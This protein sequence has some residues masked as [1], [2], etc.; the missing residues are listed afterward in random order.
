MKPFG[1][2]LTPS[3]FW[4]VDPSEIDEKQHK[5]YIIQRVL[6]RGDLSDWNCLKNHYSLKVIVEEAQ[7]MRYLDPKALAFI[8]CVGKVPKE[9]FRC[10]TTQ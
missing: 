7:K 4:D 3:L 2:M 5:R 9:S 10:T 8:C 6:E 1:E